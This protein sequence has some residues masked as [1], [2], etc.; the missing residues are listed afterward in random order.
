MRKFWFTQ[1]VF[2]LAFIFL[3]ALTVIISLLFLPDYQSDTLILVRQHNFTHYE[4][5]R[6]DV[7]RNLRHELHTQVREF[8]VPAMSPDGTQIVF[9]M[10]M[11]EFSEHDIFLLDLNTDNLRNLTLHIDNST[12]FPAWSPDGE[13]LAISVRNPNGQHDIYRLDIESGRARNLTQGE[14]DNL[15]PHWSPDGH[16]IAFEGRR[17]DDLDF[18]LIY[19]VD[20]RTRAVTRLIDIPLNAYQPR[21]SPDGSQ[22]AFTSFR[23][24]FLLDLDSGDIQQLTRDIE[25]SNDAR[26][27]SPTW[28]PDG[29]LLA[30]ITAVAWERNL[31][32]I[33]HNG[34]NLRL[35][36]NY[37]Q[38]FIVP[39]WSNNGERI[40]V[41]ANI[42]NTPNERL[43]IS[44]RNGDITFSDVYTAP[45]YTW[46]QW[47]N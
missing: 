9:S 8:G 40:A 46:V 20:A 35:L 21:W 42:L 32:V 38:D 36:A 25:D 11:P 18:T 30:F 6:Y 2:G 28:S 34:E 29:Q 45:P 14:G 44:Q 15:T 3:I 24:L 41:I 22:L 31:Y 10:W 47:L 1:S 7:S 27:L 33:D 16:T 12:S 43:I 39:A 5:I 19:A 37:V 13:Q 26:L 23:D 4:F 17:P